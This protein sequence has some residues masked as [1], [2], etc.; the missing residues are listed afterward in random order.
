MRCE[1]GL[2]ATIQFIRF[3][4]L[5]AQTAG[6]VIVECQPP[7]L[8]L[9]QA[10][11]H[12][13]R[14]LPAGA[15]LPN[16]DYWIPL[17]SIPHVVATT[18]ESI[19]SQVPYLRAE[20]SK[21]QEWRKRLSDFPR[22]RIGIAWQ[23]N[24]Q[25][26]GDRFRSIP[27]AE[28]APLARV[29]GATFIS[30]QRGPGEE[31]LVKAPFA[32]TRFGKELDAEAPF[33]DTAAL[34]ADLDLIIT[35]DTSIAHLAGSLG[36]PVWV[37]LAQRA[38]WRWML[39]RE[40]CP[41]YPTMRLF[42]QRGPGDWAEVFGRMAQALE[43]G[44]LD[45]SKPSI[46]TSSQINRSEELGFAYFDKVYV[47]NLDADAERM[48]RVAVRLEK[49]GVPYERYAALTPPE[50]LKPKSPE[51]TASH[52][53]CALSHQAILKQAWQGGLNRI[54][55]FEDDVVL[56]DD[57]PQWMR[58]IVPQLRRLVWDVF[59]LGLHLETAG[60]KLAPNLL[61]VK[62]GFHTHAYAV[63]RQAMPRLIRYIDH[64]LQ[65]LDGAF[66]AYQDPSLIKLCA[67]PILAI[68]EPNHSHTHDA[69]IN[70]AH[71]YFAAFDGEEFKA[72]CNELSESTKGV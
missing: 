15:P 37:A 23:G 30:L 33:V 4:L 27:L 67:T 5:L 9:L 36:R 16:A 32:I 42:R 2:G 38:D 6:R 3:A 71:Q 62:C 50:G 59:Y 48:R 66:D 56:R 65:Q 70:R 20:E 60:E 54:L 64:V 8:R 55:I 31:Q 72:H 12:R 69:F 52:Y 63:S 49:L 25:F 44:H 68:Q 14:L 43:N 46:H 35:S 28:F 11:R 17:M 51:F 13:L 39:E 61:E 1:Q 41:W 7:L 19:P 34:M 53:A 58:Q 47:L 18:I 10:L 22:P 57:T 29:P 45:N 26:V 24:P 21:A 40:D